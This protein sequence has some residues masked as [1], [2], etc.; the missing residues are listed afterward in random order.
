MTVI[1]FNGAEHGTGLA[2]RLSAAGAQRVIASMDQL[3][4]AIAEF[5]R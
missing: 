4:A 3:Q 5:I 1:G 2:Q